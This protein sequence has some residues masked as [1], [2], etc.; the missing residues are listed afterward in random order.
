MIPK[1]SESNTDA[2]SL[3]HM[4]NKKIVGEI[5][6]KRSIRDKIKGEVASITELE[7]VKPGNFKEKHTHTHN[8]VKQ[9]PKS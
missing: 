2:P 3:I 4:Q 7:E 6:D 8:T 9:D 1:M 5:G